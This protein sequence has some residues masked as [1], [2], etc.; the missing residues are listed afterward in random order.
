MKPRYQ[1]DGIRSFDERESP[2]WLLA[3]KDGRLDIAIEHY[4]CRHDHVSL[5]ELRDALEPF[6]TVRGD[7]RLDIAPNVCLWANMSQ[8]FA[9]AIADLERAGKVHFWPTSIMVYLAD[10]GVLNLPLA[11]RLPPGGYK[12]LRWLP[13]VMRLEP[14][15]QGKGARR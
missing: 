1:I 9:D 5:V 14:P 2:V 15:K 10:G 11:K 6:F 8:E 3:A 12:T 4:V 13:V 7:C